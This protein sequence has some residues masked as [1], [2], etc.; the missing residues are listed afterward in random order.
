MTVELIEGVNA[1]YCNECNELKIFEDF[2]KNSRGKYGYKSQCKKC[3]NEKSKNNKP[4][5]D[6]NI[7]KKCMCCG[8][9]LPA[10]LEYFGKDGKGKYGVRGKCKICAG[11]KQYGY[12]KGIKR[13]EEEKQEYEKMQRKI[14]YENNKEKF[15]LRQRKRYEENREEVLLISKK[16]YEDN[17][18][19]VLERERKRYEDNKEILKK[20]VNTYRKT[21][22]GRVVA[23]N[24]SHKRRS[25][26]KQGVG[27][28]KKQWIDCLE[29]FNNCCAYS[30]EKCEELHMEH[31]IP[32]SK[33][34]E[35]SFYNIVPCK[36]EYN[37][38]K[39][40]KN[41][42]EWYRKQT[43]FSEERLNR[44]YE[45]MRTMKEKYLLENCI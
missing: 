17:R 36:G 3:I 1:K 42:E 43:Y 31:I 2:A 44:I 32:L 10:T 20:R 25:Y 34:G 35:H 23:K 8:K 12:T 37:L 7:T 11:Q 9:E 19:Y 33:G 45:Y 5:E 4:N 30:G 27:I 13:T 22:N 14:Y 18:E 24:H 40:N 29:F 39:S 26:K 38:S 6:E 15:L 21:D 41:M 28:N 16:Y